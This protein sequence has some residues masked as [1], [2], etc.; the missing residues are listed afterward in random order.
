MDAKAKLKKATPNQPLRL[1][2]IEQWDI[3][4]DVAIV[5]FGGAGSCAAIEAADAGSDVIIF[6]LS[7][8]SGGSTRLSS[9]E[10][11]MGGNG[12]T[13]IQ[14][15]CGFDDSTEDMIKFLEMTQGE[16]GDSEKIRIYCENSLD[17]YHWLVDKG[18]KYKES[19]HK[20]RAVMALTDDCLL[21]TGNE[22]AQPFVAEAKPC[23]RGHNLEIE[24][25][26]GGP[27]LMNALTEQVEKRSDK[28]KVEYEARVLTLIADDN[29]EVHGCVVRLNM[30]EYTVKARKGVILCAGGFVMNDDMLNK[31]APKL[32]KATY[33]V[34]NPGDMG[35]GIMMGMGLG[36]NI[37]NM[38]EGF[39]SM[40]FYPPADITKGI[41]INEQGQRFIN[42]DCYHSRVGA[43]AL[44]QIGRRI[45]FILHASDDFQAPQF[46]FA[47]FAGTGETLEELA[48]EIN[49]NPA[50]LKHT[51]EYYNSNAKDG[52]DPLFEKSDEYLEEI[53]APYVAL[54]L[55]PGHGAILPYF[56]LGGLESL[57]T[58]EVLTPAGKAIKGLYAAGRTTAG[59]P[60]RAEGYAS[61]LSVGDA[62][63]F[64]RLAGKK[65]AEQTPR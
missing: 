6:E 11:Y 33:K 32:T 13:P 47:D 44:N 51:V 14:Q 9:A 30:Q 39:V 26:N 61:G 63:F 41:I 64:G 55:T 29:D 1:S 49:I 27:F 42:E 5:G 8:E 50:M 10:I 28:I 54:D 40:P 62:T 53:K 46:L 65:V 52:K 37:I 22:K 15:A 58:G 38:S 48:E 18:A 24:G 16:L 21:Y 59:V 12:G 19:F 57:P 35:T 60:R 17:H 43:Y 4:T 45:Y 34:G 7:S 3:E 56:T 20:E 36:A 2:D 25:D 31:Y 23:P